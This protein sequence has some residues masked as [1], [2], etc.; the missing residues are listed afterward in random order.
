MTR[1][2]SSAAGRARPRSSSSSRSSCSPARQVLGEVVGLQAVLVDLGVGIEAA[3]AADLDA[4]DEH[5][6]RAV[7][8]HQ[9]FGFAVASA[10]SEKRVRT[11]RPSS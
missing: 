9:H 6:G 5:A 4:V 3:L 11:P 1:P 2:S 7:R 10:G 8:A